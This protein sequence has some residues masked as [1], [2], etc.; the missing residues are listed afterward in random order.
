V[1]GGIFVGQSKR[2]DILT[3][4][5]RKDLDMVHESRV[6]KVK[7]YDTVDLLMDDFERCTT[8]CLCNGF[9]AEGVILLNDSFSEDGAQE[10]AVIIPSQDRTSGTQVDSITASWCEPGEM[11]KIFKESYL[12]YVNEPSTSFMNTPVTLSLEHPDG[13]CRH[14]Q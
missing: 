14:C 8:W 5:A 6:Y 9:E 4:D 13:V 12:S 2:L 1:A 10:Y 3:I 7:K 11:R